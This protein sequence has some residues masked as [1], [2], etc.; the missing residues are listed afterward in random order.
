MERQRRPEKLA[1]VEFRIQED[2][3]DQNRTWLPLWGF[4]GVEWYVQKPKQ[5]WIFLVATSTDNPFAFIQSTSFYILIVYWLMSVAC[6]LYS[7]ATTILYVLWNT[8]LAQRMLYIGEEH[9]T[10]FR[11]ATKRPPPNKIRGSKSCLC[12]RFPS[13]GWLHRTWCARLSERESQYTCGWGIF[14][15]ACWKRAERSSELLRLDF[16]RSDC[17]TNANCLFEANWIRRYFWFQSPRTNCCRWYHSLRTKRSVA[18]S[19]I[20]RVSSNKGEKMPSSLEG[21]IRRD[22]GLLWGGDTFEQCIWRG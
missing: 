22:L 21:F 2:I 20:Q 8:F 15:F 13:R 9:P 3:R 4:H 1:G 17:D 18:K 5:E 6:S 19:R 11:I 14:S 16:L 12:S 10:R 7:L